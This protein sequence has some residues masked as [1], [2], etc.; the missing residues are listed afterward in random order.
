MRDGR[1]EEASYCE[2]TFFSVHKSPKNINFAI[3]MRYICNSEMRNA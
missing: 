1:F 2:K 3:E